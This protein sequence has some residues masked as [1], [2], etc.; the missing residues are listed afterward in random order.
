MR[1]RFVLACFVLVLSVGCSFSDGDDAADASGTAVAGQ[2]LV[3]DIGAAR[4]LIN[5]S[6]IGAGAGQLPPGSRVKLEIVERTIAGRTVYSPIARVSV[7]DDAGDPVTGLNL[8]PAA[9]F[10]LSFDHVAATKDGVVQ[11]AGLALI[12]ITGSTTDELVHTTGTPDVDDDYVLA[13]PG[14]ARALVSS[15]S[16]FAVTGG[17]TLPPPPPPVVAMTGTTST[18]LTSTI[19]QLSNTGGSI[20]VNTAVPTALTT[21]PPAVITLNDASFNATNP[22]DVNNRIIT[23]QS[24]G[25]TYTSDAAAASVIFQLDTFTGTGS[26]GS[27]LGTVVQQGGSATLAINYTF[28]TGTAATDAIGGTVTDLGG[29]RTLN[30][31][32]AAGDEQVIALMP[33]TLPNG[34][35]DPITFDDASFDTGDPLNPASRILT[36]TEGGE[37]FSSDVPAVGSVT[38]TFTSWD[39]GTQTGAGTIT[40]TVVSATPTLK[41][42]NY[43]FTVTA[44]GT[45][46]GG[47]FTAG[48]PVDIT[49]NEAVES[50]VAYDASLD[51]YVATYLTAIGTTNRVIEMVALDPDTLATGATATYEPT[52]ALEAAGGLAMASD[53]FEGVTIVGATGDDASTDTVVAIFYD[54]VDDVLYNPEVNLGTGTAPRVVYHSLEDRYIVAWQAGTDVMVQVFDFE[55]VAVGAAVTAFSNA[56]LT[57]LATPGD[58]NDEALITADDGNGI[59]GQYVEVSTGTLTGINFSLSTS[60]SGGLCAYD[61]SGFY[62]IIT[63]TLV[64]GFFTAQQVL[65]LA[66]GTD[67]PVGTVLTLA[68]AE[69]PSQTGAGNAGVIFGDPAAN[70]YP[71]EGDVAGA[72]LVDTPVYGGFTGLNLDITADGGALAGAG[73]NRYVLLAARGGDGLTAIPLTLTP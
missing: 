56:T 58:T 21:T 44:G 42:L 4:L 11:P 16:D 36:V 48:T 60:L 68:A 57:G 64:G 66:P 72:T 33:D 23:V 27:F 40:G 24:G 14:R 25:V 43:T 19:F 50:A 63:Q 45:G 46:G 59:V 22:L 20:S 73:T 1:Y 37:T 49:A 34:T 41:T 70:L 65:A 32:D 52:L 3:L 7:T 55:G 69:A 10:E 2:D 62:L 28:T 26:S 6:S 5:G 18:V 39:N 67:V 53:N 61:E 47:G 8:S 15:F 38:L 29:F 35:L 54:F 71:V 12:K 13:W 17:A 51:V 30:L 9:V 31:Q